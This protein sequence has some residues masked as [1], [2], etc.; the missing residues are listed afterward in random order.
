MK[1]LFF[2]D[3]HGSPGK[4]H[5]LKEKAKD[6][7]VIVCAGDF[8]I[9]END[10]REILR[11]F[12]DFGKPL[13]LINGNHE[14]PSGVMIECE[15]L[16]NLHFI[17]KN[18]YIAGNIIFYGFGGGG[19]SIRDESFNRESEL[20]IAEFK[21]LSDANNKKYKLVLVTHAPPY[22]TRL[23]DLGGHV[24][25]KSVAEFILKHKP[26]VAVSGH[27]HENSGIEDRMNDTTIINPGPDGMILD[28]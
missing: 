21:G 19:F 16:K 4:M 28:I 3:T 20:F 27:L 1:I 2:V 24:G 17:H 12:N 7:D 26:I 8:T 18:Y 11:I 10:I 22:G 9:F 23:D 6:A 13:L 15:R 5:R 25:S 14:T